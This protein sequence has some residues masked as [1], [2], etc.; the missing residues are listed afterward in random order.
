MRRFPLCSLCLYGEKN[1]RKKQDSTNDFNRKG[2]NEKIP[3]C[4][5]CASVVKNI[6]DKKQDSTNDF[7]RKGRNENTPPVLFVPLW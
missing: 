2:R 3:P 1:L 5:L 7:N 6:C 4:A